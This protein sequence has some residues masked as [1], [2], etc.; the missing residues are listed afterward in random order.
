MLDKQLLSTLTEIE[1]RNTAIAYRAKAEFD[2]YAELYKLGI[3][4]EET[5]VTHTQKYIPYD[6]DK[7]I[8]REL[9]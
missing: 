1:I 5:F 6:P 8:S 4:S 9:P 2:M 7:P 3:I